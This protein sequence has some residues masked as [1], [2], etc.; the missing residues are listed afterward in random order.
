MRKLILLLL[1]IAIPVYAETSGTLNFTYYNATTGLY[2]YTVNFCN[3]TADCFEYKCFPDYDGFSS[4]S[5][6]GWCNVTASTSCYHTSNA[7]GVVVDAYATGTFVCMAPSNVTYKQCSSGVWSNASTCSSGACVGG[8]TACSTSSSG[9]GTGSG[10]G[11]NTTVNLNTSVI[12]SAF[13]GDFDIIQG[14]STVKTVIVRNNGNQTLYNLTLSVSGMS[15][16]SINPLKYSMISINGERTFNVTFAAPEN[17]ELKTYLVNFVIITNNASATRS[18]NLNMVVRPGEQT[19]QVVIIPDYSQYNTLLTELKENLTRLEQSGANVEELRNILLSAE[20]KLRLTGNAIESKDYTTATQY[21][22]DAKGLLEAA[23]AQM[24]NVEVP[25][26]HIEPVVL[27]IIIIAIAVGAFIV[28]TLLPPKY[29][30]KGFADYFGA[31]R[32]KIAKIKKIKKK[33]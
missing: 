12:F 20:S 2:G 21:L 16:A 24:Q 4:R 14:A 1:L 5:E 8:S 26:F 18:R 6:A 25:S 9:T 22:E 32:E 13:P 27:V 10:T 7:D 3:T 11:S 17:A 30:K 28:Y 23:A 33:K 29:E 15:W 31:A 19:A